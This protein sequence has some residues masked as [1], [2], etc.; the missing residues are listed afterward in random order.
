MLTF[1]PKV[2]SIIASGKGEAFYLLHILNGN[3]SLYRAS[4][5]HFNS[6]TMANGITYAAD[7]F[8]VNV[9]PPKLDTTVDREQ[10]KIT[11]ADANFRTAADAENGMVGKRVE[12]RIGFIDPDNGLP[13]T[14]MADTLCVYRGRL[15]GIS[16]TIET[17]EFGESTFVISCGSPMMSLDMKKGV[18][19]SRD[20]VRS[21]YPTDSCCD[22]V[23]TGSGQIIFKWG[24]G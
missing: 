13:L 24:K 22:K 11:L 12:A 19:L 5:T 2:V 8:I 15:D 14:T 17:S 7:D 3:G 23:Y 18:Y 1:S 21:K 20:F 10:Y 6:M 4:T 16:A 9:D